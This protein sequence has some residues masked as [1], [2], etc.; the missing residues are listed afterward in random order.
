MPSYTLEE[1]KPTSI[2]SLLTAFLPRGCI[3][4]S[5]SHLHSC[6]EWLRAD[7]SLAETFSISTGAGS[8]IEME[9]FVFFIDMF[10]ASCSLS[11]DVLRT[12]R[13]LR[14]PSLPTPAV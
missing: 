10:L 6:S 8:N 11:P 14:R 12:G 9:I 3:S 2:S 1:F 7:A 4:L 13:L 5:R